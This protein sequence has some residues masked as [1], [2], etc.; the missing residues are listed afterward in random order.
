MTIIFNGLPQKQSQNSY[1]DI[2]RMV[3][4]LLSGKM[5]ITG[6]FTVLPNM[7]ETVIEDRNIGENSFI[8]FM[9]LDENSYS[10]ELYLKSKN[11][12]GKS[13]TIGHGSSEYPRSYSYIII[14]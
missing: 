11:V 9:G 2:R 13:F 4:S 1:D 6:T 14:G 12:L 5:N 3:N 8:G 10:S 7:T